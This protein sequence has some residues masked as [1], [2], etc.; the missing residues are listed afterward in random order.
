AVFIRLLSLLRCSTWSRSARQ[1]PGPEKFCR[2]RRPIFM[3][4]IVAPHEEPFGRRPTPRSII[5]FSNSAMFLLSIALSRAEV[6]ASTISALSSIARFAP[7]PFE[8]E[9]CAASPTTD[10]GDAPAGERLPRVRRGQREERAHGARGTARFCGRRSR[11]IEQRQQA[12]GPVREDVR[13]QV[14]RRVRGRHGRD[15][16]VFRPAERQG[17]P[18]VRVDIPAA[19]ALRDEHLFVLQ[20]GE[21]ALS[22]ERRDLGVAVV[23]VRYV[24]FDGHGAGVFGLAGLRTADAAPRAVGTDDDV[25]ELVAVLL[26][27]GTAWFKENT[28]LGASLSALGRLDRKRELSNGAHNVYQTGAKGKTQ[29]NTI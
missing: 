21:Q 9:R 27:A 13:V 20:G 5:C 3:E 23:D 14:G 26:H 25:E 18:G 22:D 17:E 2:P 12:R 19:V 15:A 10:D 16:G 7:S 24:Q 29:H 28:D 6:M 4:N 11:H 8:S 1:L